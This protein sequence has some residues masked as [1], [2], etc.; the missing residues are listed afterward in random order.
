MNKSDSE[1]MAHLLDMAGLVQT[2]KEEDAD[3]LLI[4]T[5]GVRQS[6]EDR[7]IGKVHVWQN[8]RK[9]KP[10]LIIG[11]TGCMAGRDG[12]GRLRKQ[13]EE[14]DLFFPIS[15]MNKL[16]VWLKELNPVFNFDL[17]LP[18]DY[19]ELEAKYTDNYQ[20]FV[21]IQ[22]G[23]NQFCSYCVVPY[24]RG[25]EVNRPVKDILNE[26]KKLAENGCLQITLLGQ[27]VNHYIAPDVET[28]SKNNIYQKNDFAKLLWELNQI[29]G[30]ERIHFT[31]PHPIYMDDEVV[32]AL[33]LPKQIN[34]LHLPVQSGNNEILRK[35][36]RKHDRDYY[37]ELI[38]K[39]KTSK[40]DIALGTDI[41][42]G[43]CGETDDQFADTVDL[44]NECQF[45]ISYHAQYSMRS[46]TIASK[47]FL[48]DVSR[49]EKK[50]R[51]EILQDLMKK[52]TYKKNQSYVGKEVSV[53]VDK[54]SAG[55]NF[56]NS[57]EMKLTSFESDKN[58]V[59]KIVKLKIKEAD[60]WLLRGEMV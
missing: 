13:L 3:L 49:M 6:A 29:E 4:N 20:A 17:N 21:P 19:L 7:V 16:P 12:D 59:G 27:I 35:M 15:E 33:S 22:T 44:F 34:F 1:R 11:I 51:W 18:E 46:G 8:L 36:N 55:E 5:C 23:C 53:L 58:F 30:I 52:I 39:I 9:N 45:D 31:A 2:N 56:G 26:V 32:D 38:K 28:F 50:K 57:A 25:R 60:T 42:V 10:N 24:A 47:A 41:M 37:I 43:F 48:D 14:V 40:P 54:F